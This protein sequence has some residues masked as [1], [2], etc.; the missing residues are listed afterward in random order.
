M[1]VQGIIGNASLEESAESLL[2]L[3]RLAETVGV[4]VAG[5]MTQRRD[6]PTPGF[7]IGEG[8]LADVQLA[9]R[10]GNADLVIFDNE[11]SP[12]QVNN[13]D[14]A[15]G[16]KVIDRTELILQIFARR[17][18]S[19]EAQVQVE[20]A[21]LQYLV[22]RIPVSEKQAR[23]RGGIGMRGPGESPFQLRSEPMRKR[24]RDLKKRLESIQLRRNVTRGRRRL[25]SVCLVGYTNAGK[26]TL[27]NALASSAGAY[28]D[29]RLFATLDTKTRSLYLPD[30]R[31]VL[32]TDTVGFIRDLPHG[33]VASFRSTL[34]EAVEADLLLVTVDAGHPFVSDHLR[35]VK[36]TL[37]GI[38][39][40]EVNSLL[41]LNQCDK[42][43]AQDALPFLQGAYRN[44]VVT[45]ALTGAGLTELKQA[46]ADRLPRFV[47]PEYPVAELVP[48]APE[49][50]TP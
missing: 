33:L 29:D 23:F 16:I 39:A 6:R 26:S 13:I 44:S 21:Q 20:L 48:E 25:P 10:Q 35:I 37:A 45:S 49:E 27:L 4:T 50:E 31:N 30:R 24:I 1:L 17:A 2:E 7:F 18:R 9:C 41:V 46:I 42:P 38:G 22:S 11:L 14:L 8:K 19:A 32:L 40:D 15:L 5:S 12:I 47:A 34:D 28:V 43:A 3:E 36:E